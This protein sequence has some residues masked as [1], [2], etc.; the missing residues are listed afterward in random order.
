M[1][2]SSAT[3]ESS[4]VQEQAP[5]ADDL[6]PIPGLGLIRP[7]I[8]S[9][10]VPDVA[11]EVPLEPG[12]LDALMQHVDSQSNVQDIETQQSAQQTPEGV[13]GEHHPAAGPASSWT[14]EED[15]RNQERHALDIERTGPGNNVGEVQQ[16]CG[17][18]P[19]LEIVDADGANEAG[20]ASE[21]QQVGGTLAD[22][23]GG[24]S[25]MPS[26]SAESAAGEGG[27]II[28]ATAERRDQTRTK[29]S[30]FP[31]PRNPDNFPVTT[32]KL[33][34]SQEDP[35]TKEDLGSPIESSLEHQDT[36]KNETIYSEETRQDVIP[37]EKRNRIKTMDEEAENGDKA[38]LNRARQ[39]LAVYENHTYNLDD[40][41][42]ASGAGKDAHEESRVGQSELNEVDV[43][44]EIETAQSKEM[45]AVQPAVTEKLLLA[46]GSQQEKSPLSISEAA[47]PYVNSLREQIPSAGIFEELE[48][49]QNSENR[50]WEIDSTPI[51]SSSDSDTTS[52]S[53][54]TDDSDEDD[55]A[56]DGDY[57]M[58]DPEEQARILMQGDVGSDDEGNTRSSG[59][60]E[61]A[62]LRTANEKPEEVVQKPDIK[63]T[64]D[65]KIEELGSVEAIVE[66][67]VLVKAKISGEYR[68]L[69][70][71]SVLCLQDRSVVGVVSETLGRV[72]QPLYTIRFTNDEDIR[73]SGLAEKNTPVYYV[74][75]HSTF[76][77]TQPLRAVKGSDASNF[78]DEEVGADE[79][80]FSD[81]EAEAEH[82][83]QL[84][85]KKRGSKDDRNDRSALSRGKRGSFTSGSVRM[86]GSINGDITTEMNYDDIPPMGDDGYTPLAR[87]TNLHEMMGLGEGLL[88]GRHPVPSLSDR[89]HDRGRGR[90]RGR[91]GRGNR[92]ERGGRGRGGWDRYSNSQS[93]DR[94]GSF[95]NGQQTSP[96]LKSDPSRSP[97]AYAFGNQQPQPQTPT[98]A[99]PPIP[100]PSQHS[101][102]QP[103]PQR[104]QQPSFSYQN[105]T[106]P[107]APIISPQPSS[108]P[109][110]SPSPI[111]PLPQGHFNFTNYAN[112]Q[113]P[114][115]SPTLPSYNRYEPQQQQ[116]QQQYQQQPYQNHQSNHQWQNQFAGGQQAQQAQQQQQQQQMPP[117][118]SHINPAFFEALRQQREGATWPAGPR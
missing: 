69:E 73:E 55:A 65:M 113:N 23:V 96:L 112:P 6:P 42:S 78:H 54:S 1:D 103:T 70:S 88:E 95:S 11:A 60:G 16:E 84:K 37:T 83:R 86:N 110:F 21:I 109:T 91:G 63:V 25:S 58:L 20:T 71:N 46:S 75:Q 28:E 22:E 47:N 53:T 85:L 41:L 8:S 51:D 7:D 14:T 9:T 29:P 81:D 45:D 115:R 101:H 82:K 40:Q 18:T 67:T 36:T 49:A 89:G 64:E 98:F 90:G 68:V 52:D 100:P 15:L 72:Q 26:A 102:P 50:E 33:D 62:Y 3:R 97:T 77:F 105:P 107:Q 118:G 117:P 31:Q 79:M 104:H 24:T 27:L 111:S 106:L 10:E 12:L 2:D 57:A 99:L 116:Q 13:G 48:A 43:R 66:N 30:T 39:E 76:V 19:L 114:Q 59:K 32:A 94:R 93:Q 80:E 5:P 92:G 56:V 44:M 74:E 35:S 17:S 4:H 61:A 38:T 34:D 108:Y 87:P